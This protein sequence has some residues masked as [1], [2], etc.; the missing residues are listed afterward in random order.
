MRC[1]KDRH[2]GQRLRRQLELVEGLKWG[3]YYLVQFPI[4]L[5]TDKKVILCSQPQLLA[6]VLSLKD[7]LGADRCVL[8]ASGYS[9]RPLGAVS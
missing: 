2:K 1:S 5:P 6:T 9:P 4:G 7:R 8:G 3:R